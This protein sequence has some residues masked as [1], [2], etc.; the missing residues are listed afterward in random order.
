MSGLILS[1]P[2]TEIMAASWMRTHVPVSAAAYTLR[3]VMQE[4]WNDGEHRLPCDPTEWRLYPERTLVKQM[5]WSAPKKH[6]LVQEMLSSPESVYLVSDASVPGPKSLTIC[7]AGLG[8]SDI[9]RWLNAQSPQR[10]VIGSVGGVILVCAPVT[11]FTQP[12]CQE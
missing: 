7:T 5:V 11:S 6:P 2:V 8:T 3:E 1:K 9:C 4:I 10:M 12:K